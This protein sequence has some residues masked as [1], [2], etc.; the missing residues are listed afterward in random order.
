MVIESLELQDFRNYENLNI[1]FDKGT[2]VFYGGNAQGKTNILE[3]VFMG[4][5]SKSHR[6]VKDRDIIRFGEDEAHL[7]LNILKRDINYRIDIH[8][9]KQKAKGIAV[10]GVSIRKI[11]DL[12]GIANVIF[13]S[14]EDL[15][16]I[17]NGP[18][19]RRRF[20]DIELCQLDRIYTSDLIN[21][22]RVIDQ[23]NKL[24]KDPSQALK[25]SFDPADFLG[26][27]VSEFSGVSLNDSV[28]SDINSLSNQNVDNFGINIVNVGSLQGNV[29]NKSDIDTLLEIYNSQLVTYGT[30]IIRRREKFISDLSG[31][32]KRKHSELTSGGEEL[33][34]K[35]EKNVTAEDFEESLRKNAEREK[36]MG[37]SLVGPHRDDISFEVNGIDL[38]HFGS[39]GQQ[40]SAA[41]SL[42][43]SEIELAKETTGDDPVLLLDD[44]LSELDRSR[45]TMLLKQVG[46]IQTMITCTGIDD[47]LEKQFPMDR[48]YF[49]EKGKVRNDRSEKL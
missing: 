4:C 30:G 22:N 20:L 1:T 18:S 29:G 42:K 6:A 43:L 8:L 10:N 16:I 25:C 48:V 44:V 39:Q 41:L 15:G 23:K 34:I 35:Y 12:F 28:N 17:K 26:S 19:E 45:Q 38:R 49:V 27:F 36:R 11:S 33:V 9:K 47:L 31:I 13:F 37:M 32:I 3:A 14:P 46:N 5:T 2:N 7:K 40:R 21:Y 24:L